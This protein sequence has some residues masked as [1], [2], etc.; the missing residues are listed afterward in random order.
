[1]APFPGAATAHRALEEGAFLEQAINVVAVG[2]SGVGKSHVGA[3]LGHEWILAGHAVLWTPTSM[4]VQ[5]LLAGKR[6]LRLPQELAKLDNYI[7]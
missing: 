5:R 7:G 2:R 1:M 3:A 6:D 4:L